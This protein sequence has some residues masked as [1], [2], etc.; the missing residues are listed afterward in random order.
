[1]VSD[2]C[3]PT[4]IIILT[5]FQ[6]INT[7]SSV[8]QITFLCIDNIIFVPELSDSSEYLAITS[9]IIGEVKLI[10]DCVGVDS[11]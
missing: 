4:Q 2:S 7:C 10:F 5:S 11:R 9:I 3:R 8:P 1:M 6:T